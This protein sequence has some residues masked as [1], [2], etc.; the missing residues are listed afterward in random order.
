MMKVVSIFFS[1]V[2]LMTCN[3]GTTDRSGV[4][5][6]LYL[7]DGDHQ[8]LIVAFG[9]GDGGNGWTSDRVKDKREQLIAKGYAFLAVGYFG[10]AQ[11][12]GTLDRISLDAIHD[13]ILSVAN[14]RKIDRNKIALLGVSKGAE[15]ALLL[16]SHFEDISCV[17]AMAPS[18]CVFPA[19][20]FMASTSS[21]TYQGEE[22]PFV[23]MTWGAV[24]AA[25]QHDLLSAFSIMLKDTEAV[26]KAA[27][28]VEDIKG[29]IFLLSAKNDEQWPS[30]PM[31][32]AAIERLAK[33][34]FPYPYHH[35]AI[36]GGHFEVFDHFDSVYHF[37]D[38]NFPADL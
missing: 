12:P 1:L 3:D 11:S 4:D 7:G 22:V 34:N 35:V 27:I 16:A 23:P 17:V 6:Q 33:N 20:T 5:T 31:S 26:E 28:R 25:I 29:S 2:L 8:P 14:H 37:L 19:H 21:W 36:D 10:T 9:G 30:T 18:H 13:A 32:L 38:Q 15:L 24:P